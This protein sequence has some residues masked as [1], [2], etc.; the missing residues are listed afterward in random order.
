MGANLYLS[1]K[2]ERIPLSSRKLKS[3]LPGETVT[4]EIWKDP[5]NQF[6]GN[7]ELRCGRGWEPRV[8]PAR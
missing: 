6:S 1:H 4:N 5:L 7:T 3:K 8:E 2:N